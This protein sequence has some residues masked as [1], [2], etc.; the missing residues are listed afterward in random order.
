MGLSTLVSHVS[1]RPEEQRTSFTQSIP[2]RF[3]SL[4]SRHS[5]SGLHTSAEHKITNRS[6]KTASHTSKWN[7]QAQL[8]HQKVPQRYGQEHA[9]YQCLAGF[10][11][12]PQK[13]PKPAS[14]AFFNAN[15]GGWLEERRPILTNGIVDACHACKSTTRRQVNKFLPVDTPQVLLFS[16]KTHQRLLQGLFSMQMRGVRLKNGVP[17]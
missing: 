1:R 3:F 5:T 9:T 2:R 6:A 8:T 15:D 12:W 13:A 7:P 14:R 10:L 4:A 11:V 17:Y 16:H